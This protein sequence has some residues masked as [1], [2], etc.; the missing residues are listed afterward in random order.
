VH[1]TVISSS[2]NF[3]KR[4]PLI[5]HIKEQLEETKAVGKH[6]QIHWIPAHRGITGN[7]KADELVKHSVRHGGNSQIPIPAGDM[8]RIWSKK[9]QTGIPAVAPGGGMGQGTAILYVAP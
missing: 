6:V 5:S 4:S 3:R 9:I 1:T 7:E 2:K 8:K